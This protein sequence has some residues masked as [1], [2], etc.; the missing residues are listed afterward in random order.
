MIK[1][2]GSEKPVESLR[3][4]LDGKAEAYEIYFSLD[5]GF[6]VEVKDGAVDALKVRSSRGVGLRVLSEN[7]IGLAFSSVLTEDALQDI[8]TKALA[9]SREA[10]KDEYLSFARPSGKIVDEG[11]LGLVDDNYGK[12]PEE[13][14]I[15]AAIRI[16]ES[17]KAVDPRLKRVRK[18]SYQESAASARIVNSNGVDVSRRATYFS[19]SITAVAEDKGES[20][21]G[22]EMELGHKMD[23][24]D[25]AKIGRDG[26]NN[27][28]RMLGGRKIATVKCPAVLEN[29][30]ATELLESLASSF[31]ADNV[32]KGK[33]MLIGKI[34]QKVAASSLNVWDDGILPGGWATSAFDGE[35]VPK[36]KTALLTEGVLRGF[37]YDTYWARREGAGAQSTGNAARS[38]FK[39]FPSVGISNLYIEKGEKPLEGLLSDMGKG[40]FI[41]ELLGV[42]TINTVS[43][44]FSI[45][46]AGLW[47]EGGK[48]AYPVRGMAVSGNLLGL[49]SKVEGRGSDIRFIGSI[50]SPSL[51]ITEI[52]ASGS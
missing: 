34:G 35:G 30:V 49:F 6:G 51:L 26:A 45:G 19:G 42:H 10:A 13:K 37:L 3:K 7:R 47:V 38:G 27:A 5:E 16:E 33:S 23:S 52:E 29:V 12:T 1:N 28:L 40:L 43:G 18:A 9:G 25:P 41:T 24:L 32:H 4:F 21:M 15:E 44:D 17:A 11:P 48:A 31:L 50:G 22:W 14:K 2:A 20:Q 39:G 8:V 46:A 36:R